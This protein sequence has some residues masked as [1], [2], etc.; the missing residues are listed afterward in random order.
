MAQPAGWAMQYDASSVSWALLKDPAFVR[1]HVQLCNI[2]NNSA[3]PQVAALVRQVL[4]VPYGQEFQLLS[5]ALKLT[6]AR[7]RRTQ[8]TVGVGIAVGAALLALRWTSS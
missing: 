6:C 4:P 8:Q 5:D 7:S 2:L 1:L 3:E